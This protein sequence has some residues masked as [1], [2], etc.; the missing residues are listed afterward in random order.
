MLP[1]FTQFHSQDRMRKNL[2]E[3]EQIRLIK[4]AGEQQV[5]R[6]GLAEKIARWFDH[7]L[8]KLPAKSPQ[9][10]PTPDISK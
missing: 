4:L 8:V 6:P 5:H 9:G 10:R 1:Q 7:Q 3:A 2:R